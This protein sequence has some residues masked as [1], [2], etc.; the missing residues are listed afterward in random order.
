MSNS[1]CLSAGCPFSAGGKASPCTQTA[2]ILS[3]IEIRNI[4]AG[5][6]KVTLDSAAAV[7]I[8]TWDA[9]QWVSYDDATT[10]K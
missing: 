10:M 4:I 3:A 8:V 7:Q 1:G 5:G 9:N 2:G 6:A